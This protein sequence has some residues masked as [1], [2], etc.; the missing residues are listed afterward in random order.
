MNIPLFLEEFHE[1]LKHTETRLISMNFSL[2]NI[3]GYLT[4]VLK[5]EKERGEV[6]VQTILTPTLQR[7]PFDTLCEH[8]HDLILLEYFGA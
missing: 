5:V 8:L 7:Y 6:I 3:K 2:C 1:Y 4:L